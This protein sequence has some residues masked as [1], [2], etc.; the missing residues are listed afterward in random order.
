MKISVFW[1]T[2]VADINESVLIPQSPRAA[3]PYFPGPFCDAAVL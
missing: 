2:P 1:G 3:D